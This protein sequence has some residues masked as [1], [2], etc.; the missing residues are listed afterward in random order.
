LF[1]HLFV[2]FSFLYISFNK[3][4]CFIR[5]GCIAVDATKDVS[6]VRI[7]FKKIAMEIEGLKTF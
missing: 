7:K 4:I 3:T 6:E 1:S 5:Y 2:N